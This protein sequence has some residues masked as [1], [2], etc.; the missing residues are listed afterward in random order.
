M[1]LK[2]WKDYFSIG[3]KERASFDDVESLID[4]MKS[5]TLSANF[6]S[7]NTALE[8]E[9][10]LKRTPTLFILTESPSACIIYATAGDRSRWSDRRIVLRSNTIG[11]VKIC[12]Q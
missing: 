12:V 11:E 3:T 1:G 2:R 6:G 4:E 9:H 8:I 10:S 5:A 7:I